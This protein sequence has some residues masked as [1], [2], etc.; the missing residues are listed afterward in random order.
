MKPHLLTAL[1]LVA[2]CI[3][4]RA[5]EPPQRTTKLLKV[6]LADFDDVPR[7]KTYTTEYFDKLFFGLGEP[8]TTPEGRA[9]GGSVREYFL[10][11]SN[12]TLDVAG[13]VVDW[14]RIGRNITLVPHWKR[15]MEP[16]GESWPIIV[17]ETLRG[18]GL[19]GEGAKEKLRLKDG[20][21]PELLVFLNTDWGVGGCNRG[22]G[23]LKTVL[24][25][26]KLPELWDDT[27]A[28][29][30]GPLSSYSATIWRKAPQS[31][32]DGTLDEVPPAD[33]LELFPLSIMMHEMGHQLAGMPDLYGPTYRP[34]GVFDLM[35]GPAASTHFPM[36]FSAFLRERKGWMRF[37]DPPRQT[38]RDLRLWPLETHKQAFRFPQGPQQG[39]I[40]V[41]NRWRLEYPRDYGRPPV[42][43]G[44]R[45][46][47]YHLDP[48]GRRRFMDG[49]AMRKKV[50]TV[51]RRGG[52]Y[53]EMWGEG[54]H[55]EI[56]A[57][58][59]PSS[60][61][62][63]GELWWE[64]RNMAPGSSGDMH[65][66]AEFA[67]R[68]LVQQFHTATWTD[69][70]GQKIAPGRFGGGKDHVSIATLPADD[71]EGGRRVLHF[72]TR[73]GGV[74]TARFERPPGRHAR[75]YAKVGLP[76][77]TTGAGTFSLRRGDGKDVQ[78][79]LSE[80][81]GRQ[82]MVLDLAGT[83]QAAEL[84]LS[85]AD[86]GAGAKAEIIDAW[87]V[88]TDIVLDL[89]DGEVAQRWSLK[90]VKGR[91]L[92]DGIHYGPAV[93]ALTLRG[94]DSDRQRAECL[95]P[96]PQEAQ[97]LRAVVGLGAGAPPG[98]GAVVS[99]SV[100]RA[101][102]EWPLIRGLQIE[103]ST[104]SSPLPVI[105]AALPKEVCGRDAIVRVEAT[106]RGDQPV[107]VGFSCL[108]LCGRSLPPKGA[109]QST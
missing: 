29:F 106:R 72:E 5:A 6:F 9:I 100:L 44:P 109:L 105:A 95:L 2:L 108:A 37:D 48:A 104:A 58:T 65:L 91:R 14:V 74:L 8:R 30:P 13:E 20:R 76:A 18:N 97:L 67:P 23:H 84:R 79:A 70:D 63:L 38:V 43:K 102:R 53:G 24:G 4:A 33:E 22:W 25:K 28:G 77:G 56:T 89:S 75:L 50:T 46:L 19:V 107:V 41:E 35:G 16:F 59:S 3:P 96:V 32:K 61:N 21:M 78:L 45:L 11:V 34:W 57:L 66:D 51:L 80:A 69:T 54:E 82:T 49:G 12:G 94:S 81:D 64:F 15:G 101:E 93:L 36:S 103:A 90:P 39:S 40:V 1:C 85:A 83:S 88:D 71:P 10:D 60:R 27:W 99:V 62:S 7:P 55:T 87:L 73:P 86:G 47:L 92:H 31:K 42:N 17:A 26:M 68:D 52:S 98:A